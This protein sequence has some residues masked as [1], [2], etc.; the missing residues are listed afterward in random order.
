MRTN[1][2]ETRTNK[3]ISKE[4]YAG[5]VYNLEVN[6]VH[7]NVDD[8][9]Y[10]C[11][12]TGIVVHNCH[13]RDNIALRWMAEK[14]DLGYDL[15]GSIMNAREVQTERIANKVIS[16]ANR[17]PVII[18]GEAYKPGVPYLEGSGSL[19]VAH[20]IRKAGLDVHFL[21]K[22]TGSVPHGDVELMPCVYLLM[23]DA[24]ITYCDSPMKDIVTKQTFSPAAGSTIIDIWRKQPDI[25]GCTVIHDGNTRMQ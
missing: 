12:D 10:V 21:D 24:E 9:Y 4:L 16:V 18:V 15:F 14:L 3:K 2:V 11:A 20:Y 1:R 25:D 17:R 22:Y 13:P 8:Q 5:K 19:L 6:P 23:H 7:P